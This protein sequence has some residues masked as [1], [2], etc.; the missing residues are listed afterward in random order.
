VTYDQVA[1]IA[2]RLLREQNYHYAQT[3]EQAKLLLVLQWGNT[4]APNGA[5]KEMNVANANTALEE[6]KSMLSM[7]RQANPEA[8][9]NARNPAFINNEAA[10]IGYAAALFE[11]QMAQLLADNRQRDELNGYNAR[12]LGYSADVNESDDIRR[13][14]GGGDRYSDLMGDVEET[15]Y[16]III[17]AYDFQEL[18]K[19]QKQKQLWITRVSVRSP[20]NSFDDSYLAMLKG[21]A[22]YFGRESGKLVRGEQP[23]GAVELGDLK[24]LGEA[25]DPPETRRETKK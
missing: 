20:G 10:A 5:N 13:W 15:R 24:F 22:P 1:A 16:Y 23:K 9:G 19:H 14:A 17:T 6:L 3:K 4:I 2:M 7:P 11:S 12:L 21:A 8:L 18:L 25:K